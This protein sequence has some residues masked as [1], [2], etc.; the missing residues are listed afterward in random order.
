[1]RRLTVSKGAGLVGL[2]LSAGC[3]STSQP[4]AP[5]PAPE[6]VVKAPAPVDPFGAGIIPEDTP[7]PR[8]RVTPRA[9]VSREDAPREDPSRADARQVYGSTHFGVNYVLEG[10]K[11]AEGNDRSTGARWG[12]ALANSGL[13]IVNEVPYVG[14]IV[15]DG[16]T[17]REI[18]WMDG[19]W[20]WTRDEKG[21]IVGRGAPAPWD[22]TTWLMAVP[23]IVATHHASRGMYF[24]ENAAYG[25]DPL[26]PNYLLGLPTSIVAEP[27]HVTD[28]TLLGL[29]NYLVLGRDFNDLVT[30]G[31]SVQEGQR[32]IY[33]GTGESIFRSWFKAARTNAAA[34][35]LIYGATSGG[36]GSGGNGG[37][38][39]GTP[40]VIDIP[41]G[42][43]TE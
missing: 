9:D 13:D 38:T 43:G 18:G 6:E 32:S 15:N 14:W 21:N 30:G 5:A 37:V 7:R 1:M 19:F 17:R 39:P 24:L 31:A 34:G 10:P 42:P 2:A 27:F 35:A 25:D 41:I 28:K 23:R 36:G 26:N 12:V 3:A 20:G 22:I 33:D 16:V 4:P 40:P 11:D 29:G 8:Q